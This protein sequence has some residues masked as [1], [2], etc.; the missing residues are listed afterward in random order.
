M[1]ISVRT[2]RSSRFGAELSR[3]MRA[4][5]VTVGGLATA[6]GMSEG[7]LGLL[8]RGRSYPRL[9][10]ALALSDALDWVPLGRLARE[11][12]VF[13]CAA[14]G[15]PGTN[16]SVGRPRMYCDDVC[17]AL[18]RKKGINIPDVGPD[19][20]RLRVFSAAVAAMCRGCEPEGLCRDNDCS[21]RPVSPL[22][23]GDHQRVEMAA[24]AARVWSAARRAVVRRAS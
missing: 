16:E 14:C 21:L 15:Q 23:F 8:R 5:D 20:R 6:V 3:A 4:R 19:T 2:Q 10:T 1:S 7:Q 18:G 11:E 17:A 24:P 13:T 12:H 22:P 9:A